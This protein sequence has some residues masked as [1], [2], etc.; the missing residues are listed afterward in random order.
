M[1]GSGLGGLSAAAF[2]TK[3]G[4]SVLVV[5]QAA[6]AGGYAHAFERGPYTFDPAIHRMPQGGPGALPDLLFRMLGIRDRIEMLEEDCQYEAFFPDLSIR[7]PFGME[8]H[9]ET[10]CRAFPS[11]AEGIREFFTVCEKV[12]AENHAL[13]PQIG[14]SGLDEAGRRFPTLFKYLRATVDEAMDDFLTDPRARAACSVLWPYVGTPPSRLSF[15]SFA[16]NV[17]MSAESQHYCAGSFQSMVDGFLWAV[18]SNGG[19]LVVA[20]GA[21]RIV[22]ED[23]RARGVELEGGQTVSTDIVVSNADATQTFEELVGEELLPPR[24]MKRLR[25]MR[26]SC[27]A[28]VVATATDIDLHAA[29][30]APEVFVYGHY[31]QAQVW[32]DVLEGRPGG[33]WGA[34]PTLHDPSLA[35]PGEHI[36]VFT[37]LA[38][39]DIGR[40][41]EDVAE[42]FADRLLGSFEVAIPGLR[43][44]LTHREVATPPIFFQ[45]TRNRD[46]AIYGWENTPEQTG[47]RR[48][49]HHTPVEGLFLSGHWT[50]PGTA[51]LRVIVSGLHTAQMVLTSTGSPPLEIEH[52][53]MPAV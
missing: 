46:G 40:P 37:S 49:P 36:G 39:Y 1:I 9:I 6:A 35:P 22:V 2:L 31:D 41:W 33:V 17:T 29:G 8:Q 44:S 48:S 43:E 53:D 28:V 34:F 32:Q 11:E 50:L 12:H 52:P 45:Y 18:E 10:H 21:K 27:S 13:P 24:F 51:S 3:A 20:N 38:P 4:R 14:L 30:V 16:I 25:R 23:G 47:G 42:D 5:E 26:P 19:E 15:V 7:A